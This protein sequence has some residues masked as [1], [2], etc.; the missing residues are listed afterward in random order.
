[1][2]SELKWLTITCAAVTALSL[3]LIFMPAIILNVK[4]TFW[5]TLFCVVFYILIVIIILLALTRIKLC[6]TE[7]IKCVNWSTF[8][9]SSLLVGVL[10]LPVILYRTPPDDPHIDWIS[11]LMAFLGHLLLICFLIFYCYRVCYL[12]RNDFW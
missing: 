6:Q 4:P 7:D 10:A 5:Y 3:T 11:A 12:H 8:V 9:V 1:M 2:G